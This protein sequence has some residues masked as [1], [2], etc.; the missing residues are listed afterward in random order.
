[1]PSPLDGGLLC[2]VDMPGGNFGALAEQET[3]A[4]SAFIR[5]PEILR[6]TLDTFAVK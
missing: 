3:D 5:H 4:E 6:I 2:L 1:M